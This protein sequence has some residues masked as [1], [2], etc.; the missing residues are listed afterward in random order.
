ME[1]TAEQIALMTGGTVEGDPKVAVSD[2]AKI[3]E[4][5]PGALSFL[6]N[7][8]YEQF[9]YTTKSSI[10]LVSRDFVPREAVPA[11]MIRVDDPYVT[12]STLLQMVSQQLNPR[13][14]GVE[15]G[16]VIAEGV[17]VPDDAY[18]GALAYVDNGVK[19]GRGVQIY[20]QVYVGHN[21]TIGDGTTVYPGAR[22][23]HGC[24]IGRNCVI[25][26]GAV[27][28]GDGF[29]FAPTAEG[30][31]EKI[32]QLGIVE[33]G[34]NVEIGANATID[35]AVM[36]ATR[37]EDGVKIDNLVQIAHNCVI[38]RNTVMAAQC[39]IAGSTHV[40]KNC[41]FGGQVGVAGHI[42]IGDNVKIGAQSGIPNTVGDNLTLM[43]YPAVNSRDFA[44]NLVYVKRIPE[45]KK[46]I[47]A[48]KKL[49]KDK[50]NN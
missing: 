2:F 3:E 38:S 45:L 12:L 42:S 35:R 5:R 7:P 10:V 24:R 49:L 6:S 26:A 32:P 41:M 9:I 23:Y 22:I 40:G 16:S 20:P 33:I 30:V 4:G 29:G 44:R 17:E 28:G 21:V 39:G 43:G 47:E 34:D 19:L 1:F 27:I 50:E 18:V 15:Q 14:R 8:K 31:Y 36:G 46:E 25:H 11:T 37:I 13:R 48:L